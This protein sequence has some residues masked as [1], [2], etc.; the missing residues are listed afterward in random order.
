VARHR[1]FLFSGLFLFVACAKDTYVPSGGTGG[2]DPSGGAPA[3]GGD[4]SGGNGGNDGG[5]PGVGGQGGTSDCTEDPCKLVVPQCGCDA[6]DKCTLDGGGDR[7]CEADEG[8]AAIGTA[9]DAGNDCVAGAICLGGATTGYCGEFCATDAECEGTICGVGLENGGTPIPDVLLCSSA[10]DPG[11]AGGCPAGLGCVLGQEEAGQMRFLFLC[12]AAGA[13]TEGASCTTSANCAPGYGC[14]NNPG[15]CFRNCNVN[16]P[17][18]PAQI[19]SEI[20]D[21]VT[22]QPIVVGTYALGVC[23]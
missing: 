22:M 6:G 1:A 15:A 17:N 23:N 19:C 7:A 11:N 12:N 21:N 2:S 4:P 14:Y 3:Q 8:G 16:A 5:Q 10:C 9:C 20:T 13:G 18:C